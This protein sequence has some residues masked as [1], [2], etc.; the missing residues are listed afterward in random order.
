[1]GLKIGIVGLPNVGKSTVFNALIGAHQAAANNYPFCTIQPNRAIVP[2]HDPRLDEIQ[3][4]INVPKIIYATIEFVDI[5]GLV[6]GASQGEG[7]GN[8]FLSNIRG[9]DAL[10]HVVRCFED[11]NIIHVH[12]KLDPIVDIETIQLELVISDLEQLERKIYRL[13]SDVKG[14]KKLGVVLDFAYKLKAHLDDGKP[15]LNYPIP[16]NE[17]S[18]N[19]INEMRFLTNRPIIYTANVDETGLGTENAYAKTVEIFANDQASKYV[20]FCAKLEEELIDMTVEDQHEYLQLTGN[21]ENGLSQVVRTGFDVLNLISFFTKNEKEV[22][23]WSIPQGSTA[24]QAAGYIHTDFERG[25]IRAEVVQYKNFLKHG[26]D[27]SLKAAGL[28]RLEGKEYIVQD[29]DLIYFRFNV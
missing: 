1:M 18:L 24:P 29:G 27:A 21:V 23:A 12:G 4:L 15:I 25:F 3:N 16:E 19:L 20:V 11:P 7:L 13:V 6:K 8:Q 17:L 10:V 14:D 9:V 26:S 22:R 28:M 2:F 5:A